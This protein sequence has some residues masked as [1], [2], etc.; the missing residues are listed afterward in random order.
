MSTINDGGPAFP[1]VVPSEGAVWEYGMTL[2]D[3]FAG[4]ALMG[5]MLGARRGGAMMLARECYEMADAMLAA[6]EV[7]P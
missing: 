3:W 5:M 7:K 4:Q 1:V 6:R 2:R